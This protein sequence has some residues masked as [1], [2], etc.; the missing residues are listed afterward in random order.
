MA[1]RAPYGSGMARARA[2]R[3]AP[4]GSGRRERLRSQQKR[5]RIGLGGQFKRR[6]TTGAKGHVADNGAEGRAPALQRRVAGRTRLADFLLEHFCLSRRCNISDAMLNRTFRLPGHSL[7]NV[8]DAHSD[9]PLQA[10]FVSQRECDAKRR[11]RREI[12]ANCGEPPSRD[13]RLKDESLR[14]ALQLDN[15]RRPHHSALDAQH[16][17]RLSPSFWRA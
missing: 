8:R 1:M 14:A 3:S 17:G 5:V 12:S 4:L 9:L 13:H 2:V 7:I 11:L 16:M 6:G 10:H 15:R